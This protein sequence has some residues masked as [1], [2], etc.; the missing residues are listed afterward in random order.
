MF[1]LLHDFLADDDDAGSIYFS[2]ESRSPVIKSGSIILLSSQP[3]SIP[4]TATVASYNLMRKEDASPDNGQS[5]HVHVVVVSLLDLM[6]VLSMISA[7]GGVVCRVLFKSL[8]IGKNGL[9]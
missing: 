8:M 4:A 6:G 3:L 2:T 5:L 9:S 7:E 1:S